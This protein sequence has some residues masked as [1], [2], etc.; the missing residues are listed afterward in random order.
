M[1]PS[2]PTVDELKMQA[3]RLRQA[4]AARGAPLAQ[5]EAL[6]LLARQYGLRDWNTL[7]ARAPKSPPVGQ[8]P[9]AAQSYTV[10]GEVRGRYLDQPF[11]GRVVSLSAL[12]GGRL[13]IVIQFDE[14]VDVVTFDS[15]SAYRS[16]IT[17]QIDADGISPQ[18]TSNGV[19]HL[20][21]AR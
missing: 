16:R 4:M 20:V 1:T 15:F 18:K 8:A 3:K 5:A 21:L 2:L 7:S 14:P 6:E 10:G 13:R 19:P 11:R 9:A 12:S 17:A